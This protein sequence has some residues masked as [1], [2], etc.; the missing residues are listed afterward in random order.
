VVGGVQGA[1]DVQITKANISVVAGDSHTHTHLH[2]QCAQ[3][4]VK[5]ILKAI[6]NLRKIQQDTLAKATPGTVEWLFSTCYFTVWWDRSGNFKVLWGSG[7][8]RFIRFYAH[9]PFLT[10][11][12]VAGA[13][14]T[15]V[16]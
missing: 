16:A 4:D 12:F 13:G 11:H 5:A 9:E 7:I 8:R 2:Y 3:T 10:R 6:S 1:R 14:K 15:V